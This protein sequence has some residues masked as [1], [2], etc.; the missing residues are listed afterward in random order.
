MATPL[1]N[2]LFIVYTPGAGGRI[3]NVCAS[4]SSNVANWIVG[5]LPDPVEYTQQKFCNPNKNQHLR[6]EPHPPYQMSWFTRQKPFTRGDDLSIDQACENLLADTTIQKEIHANKLICVPYTKPYLPKWYTSKSIALVNDVA[7]D[8][9]LLQRRREVFY[10][11]E[12]N[13]VY[14]IR[15]LSKFIHNSHLVNKY[16][17][18]PQT[19]FPIQDF[20]EL[21]V[22][23]LE[24]EKVKAEFDININLSDF[25][26]CDPNQLWD[27]VLPLTGEVNRQWCTPALQTWRK[28]WI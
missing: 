1:D 26:T 12:N 18:Q 23:D 27:T 8:E 28:F 14:K 6:T 21:L 2:L 25:L 19:D 3:L 7:S 5:D 4:T 9:W 11:I 20:E 10:K 24:Q 13:T 15:F 16:N 17:D 22:E